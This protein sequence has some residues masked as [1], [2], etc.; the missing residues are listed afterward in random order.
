M[1]VILV[2][3]EETFLTQEK[4]CIVPFQ[5]RKVQT[6]FYL[7]SSVVRNRPREGASNYEKTLEYLAAISIT[8]HPLINLGLD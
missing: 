6:S 5:S 1:R 4:K 3:N 7:V 8:M 2:T